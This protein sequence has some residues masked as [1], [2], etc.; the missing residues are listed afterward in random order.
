MRPAGTDVW[1]LPVREGELRFNLRLD[2]GEWIV[3]DGVAAVP[4][5]FGSD[6]GVVVVEGD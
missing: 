1:S 6:V 2:G 4:D 5:E 3:P